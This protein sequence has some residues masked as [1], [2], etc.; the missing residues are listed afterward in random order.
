MNTVKVYRWLSVSLGHS[1]SELVMEYAMKNLWD[2]PRKMHL[3]KQCLVMHVWSEPEQIPLSF[4]FHHPTYSVYD[5]LGRECPM[6]V[7]INFTNE[8]RMIYV[9]EHDI[10]SITRYLKQ[11]PCFVEQLD[12]K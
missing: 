2:Y 9:K 4:Y 3:A 6:Y 5:A 12:I 7:H 8:S 1:L 10:S 11:M